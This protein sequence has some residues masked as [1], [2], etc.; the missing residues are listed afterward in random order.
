MERITEASPQFTARL[1]GVFYL[2]TIL[3]GAF[4]AFAGSTHAPYSKIANLVATLCYIAV[5]FLFYFIFRPVSRSISL[6]SGILSLVGC[7]LGLLSFFHIAPTRI[8]SLVFF[9]FYC[10]LIGFLIIRSAF[11]PR[12][13]GALM[14]FGGLGW[15]TFLLP[16]LAEHLSP[17]NMLPGIIGEGLLTLWLLVFGLNPERWKKQAASQS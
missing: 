16:A 9:G 6:L 4:A 10:L 12:I 11:L 1:A 3:A 8:N 17:Y 2:L 13:L 15:L 5:T 7:T 14:A